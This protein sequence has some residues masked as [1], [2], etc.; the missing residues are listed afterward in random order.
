MGMIRYPIRSRDEDSF[1]LRPLL[2]ELPVQL[3][4]LE[5]FFGQG[6]DLVTGLQGDD[7]DKRK[8]KSDS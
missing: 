6:L 2:E 7:K 3:V 8:R 1:H 5:L 4:D